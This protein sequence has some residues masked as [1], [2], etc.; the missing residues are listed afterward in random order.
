MI[1]NKVLHW[2]DIGL[3]CKLCT[4]SHQ[5]IGSQTNVINKIANNIDFFTDK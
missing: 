2:N 1:F 3:Q 5:D 4:A